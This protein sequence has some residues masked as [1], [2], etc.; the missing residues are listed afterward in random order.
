MG[1]E[2]LRTHLLVKMLYKKHVK[3]QKLHQ[4]QLSV[5]ERNQK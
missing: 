3:A 4:T 2:M 5:V 1:H